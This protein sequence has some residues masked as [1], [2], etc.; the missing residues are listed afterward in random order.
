MD[1]GIEKRRY[2]RINAKHIIKCDRIAQPGEAAPL[3]GYTKNIS[4]GGLLFESLTKYQVG[5]KLKIE[6]FCPDCHKAI[7]EFS[8]WQAG[9]DVYRFT[10]SVIRVTPAENEDDLF[11]V[12]VAI[13][14]MNDISLN[15]F[16]DF[17][18]KMGL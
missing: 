13:T 9:K 18:A 1:K 5:E 12:A 7:P 17:A 15:L 14:G 3:P 10:C 11:T 6:L 16:R 2:V 4:A 8:R